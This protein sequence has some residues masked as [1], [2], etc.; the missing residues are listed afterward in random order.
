MRAAVFDQTAQTAQV[1]DL[2][3]SPDDSAQAVPVVA[4]ALNPVDLAIASG[5]L[6]FRRLPDGAVLGFEGVAEEQPGKYVYFSAA[7]PPWGSLAE[8]VDLTGAEVVDVPTGVEPSAAAAIGV[9]GIAA[10]LALT[11]AGRFTAG[12]RVLVLGGTGS[13]GRI[14]AQ[15]ALALGADAVVATA[16]GS[17]SYQEVEALGAQVV[18]GT[19]AETFDNDLTGIGDEGFDVVIDTIWGDVAAAALQHL[20]PGA[21]FAQVGN[22]ASPSATIMAPDFRNR[23]AALV[24]HSNFLATAE[25]RMDAYAQVANLLQ[26]GRLDIESRTAPLDQLSREWTALASG[27]NRGKVVIV[28]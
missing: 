28:P 17:A 19:S 23:A 13:V 7:Q 16:R 14:A 12:D 20:R 5:K 21:R 24:G 11:K 3:L 2:E 26:Q 1:V 10:Y 8:R 27:T 25:Q 18:S 6:P 9:P 15:V 22:S 4:A